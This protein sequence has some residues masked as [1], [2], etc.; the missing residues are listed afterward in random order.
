MLGAAD[1]PS[2]DP[3]SRLA[4][5]HGRGGMVAMRFDRVSDRDYRIATDAEPDIRLLALNATRLVFAPHRYARHRSLL[6]R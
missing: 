6:C 4:F 3:E 2:A 1:R 5:D